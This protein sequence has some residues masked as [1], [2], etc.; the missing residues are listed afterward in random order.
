LDRKA[1][2]D[3]VIAAVQALK[4]APSEPEVDDR[5]DREKAADER[6]FTA[7]LR[8]QEAIYAPL[9]G[10]D[11]TARVIELANTLRTTN[12]PAEWMT[13][14]SALVDNARAAGSPAPAP[15]AGEG[16]QNPAEP[17]GDIGLPEGDQAPSARPVPSAGRRESGIVGAVRG[18][19]AEAGIG[20]RQP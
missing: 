14:V 12:D 16:G 18:I 7:E 1:T 10:K 8:V 5:T 13:A 6:A 11:V 9:Y 19:F 4:A 17:P 3:E 15:A 20:S 2:R